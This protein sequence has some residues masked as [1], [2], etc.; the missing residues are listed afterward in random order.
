MKGGAR[1]TE[2]IAGWTYHFAVSVVDQSIDVVGAAG[3]ERP[4]RVEGRQPI[5]ADWGREREA[6]A[7]A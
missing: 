4:G 5:M 7:G 1:R 6:G 2:A 3:H